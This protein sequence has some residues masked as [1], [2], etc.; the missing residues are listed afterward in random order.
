MKVTF[1]HMGNTYLA[2]KA[3]FEDLGVDVVVPLPNTKRTLE[4][5]T[6]YAPETICLPLKINLGNYI[7][8]IEKGRYDHRDGKQVLSIWVLC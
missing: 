3:L 5:G 7:E 2:G 4:L 1:P 8:S 6:K